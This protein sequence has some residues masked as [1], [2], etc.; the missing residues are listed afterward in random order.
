MGSLLDAGA[1]SRRFRQWDK[2]AY[3]DKTREKQRKQELTKSEE[4][5][6]N[7]KRP[8]D[9][10]ESDAAKPKKLK[11]SSS[12]PWSKNLEADAKF[13]ARHEKKVR[14]MQAINKVKTTDGQARGDENGDDDD[15]AEDWKTELAR[16][17]R[18]KRSSQDATKQAPA[19][20]EFDL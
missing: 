10:S 11:A 8:V 1:E 7:A 15:T 2:Y 18:A 12:V 19:T 5:K 9:G 20:F 13:K 14:K 6:V 16:A 17:K 3:A 4:A